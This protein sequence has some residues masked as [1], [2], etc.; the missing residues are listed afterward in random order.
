MSLDPTVPPSA[1]FGA[2]FNVLRR[3]WG[4]FLVL[5][6]VLIIVGILAIGAPLCF[7]LASVMVFGV[8][9]LFG[10]GIHF[11][12][13]ILVREWRGFF[14]HMLVGVLSLIIGMW[15]VDHPIV[16]AEVLT[17]VIAAFLLVGGLF[18][19]V[20]SLAQR[21]QGWGW[22]LINGIISS[23]LG[24][25]IWRQL[26]GSALWVIGLFIGIDLIF[27]GWAWVMLAIA[28]RSAP[29]PGA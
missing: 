5:G 7:T 3:N 13:A 27:N 21:F 16:G 6:I 19:M 17:L 28:S 1:P 8:L 22:V 29:Q 18:R 25:M 23:V 26:P 2:E 12:Q 9:L 24:I 11:V 4:W 20:L 15:L 10:A 14:L